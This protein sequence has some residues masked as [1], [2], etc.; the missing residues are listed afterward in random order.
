MCLQLKRGEG[1]L[2]VMQMM[3]VMEEIDTEWLTWMTDLPR[4]FHVQTSPTSVFFL[5][6]I[7]TSSLVEGDDEPIRPPRGTVSPRG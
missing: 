3:T 6:P 7:F 4:Q 1:G 2:A 5:Q